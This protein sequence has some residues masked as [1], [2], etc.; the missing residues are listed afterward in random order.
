MNAIFN[1]NNLLWGPVPWHFMLIL[2][3][4]LQ[5]VQRRVRR[6]PGRMTM[7]DPGSWVTIFVTG[8]FPILA[9]RFWFV[10]LQYILLSMPLFAL[11]GWMN[12]KVFG[13]RYNEGA[14]AHIVGVYIFILM[15]LLS[16]LVFLVLRVLKS[17]F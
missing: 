4:G 2:L 3:T 12:E 11:G 13:V 17:L 9:D 6:Q 7:W 5:V 10:W 15:S 16:V 1:L 8:F 14:L